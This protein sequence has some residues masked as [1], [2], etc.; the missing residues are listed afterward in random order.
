MGTIVAF[1][2][3]HVQEAADSSLGDERLNPL[4]RGGK[5]PVLRIHQLHTA[6]LTGV[7]H[8]SG[9]F[10]GSREGLLA[11]QILSGLGRGQHHVVVEEVRYTNGDQ[12]DIVPLEH[13]VVLL[14]AVGDI[15]LRGYRLQIVDG[16]YCHQLG[17]LVPAV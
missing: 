6:V 11:D 7:D 16:R 8:L 12:V 9:V 10:S 13:F 3:F 15:P 2:G 1:L 14:V 17:M 5:T 4:Q